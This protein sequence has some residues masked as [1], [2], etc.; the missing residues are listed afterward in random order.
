MTIPNSVVR[1][2]AQV[3][4]Q[5][6]IAGRYAI[7][8]EIGR[9]GMATVYQARDLKL[10]RSVAIKVLN[11]ELS[12]HPTLRLRFIHEARVVAQL[13]HPNIVR[14]FAVE[15]H[16]DLAF[17]I[18]E[19]VDGGTVKEAVRLEGPLSPYKAAGILRDVAW[20]LAY[21]HDH[22]I[23]HRDVKPDNILLDRST[24]RA[25][26]GDFG[27]ALV[28]QRHEL[29]AEGM[30]L[31]TADYVSPEQAAGR[32]IDA[33]SD[34]YSL[35]AA[36]FFMLTGRPPFVASDDAKILMMH[37]SERAP[38]V[39]SFRPDLPE[40]LTR[41]VNSCLQKQPGARYPHSRTIA[42]ELGE[43]LAGRHVVEPEIRSL[44][45]MTSHTASR[46]V[47][48][49]PLS[50][51]VVY[52]LE[53]LSTFGV[54]DVFLLI[55]IGW[56]LSVE[57]LVRPMALFSTVRRILKDGITYKEFRERV[58]AD[59]I[60]DI[61]DPVGPS[62]PR[63]MLRFGVGLLAISAAA[64]SLILATTE[65]VA[66]H[67]EVGLRS[68]GVALFM[69]TVG[70]VGTL[71]IS[72][73]GGPKVDHLLRR[74]IWGGSFGRLLF[75]VAGFRLKAAHK[76]GAVKRQPLEQLMA[77]QCNSIIDQLSSR[78]RRGLRQVRKALA[79]LEHE[80]AEA[81]QRTRVLN[82][83]LRKVRDIAEE[84]D[85]E[86]E[87]EPVGDTG[88]V[89]D[90]RAATEQELLGAL[91][92]AS[93]RLTAIRREMERMRLGLIEVQAGSITVRELRARGMAHT[94]G[95][96]QDRVDGNKLDAN[97]ATTESRPA[98]T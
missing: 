8:R 85:A 14:V 80:A 59:R 75:K 30:T 26:I 82:R 83:A 17:F 42:D 29:T 91:R 87:V 3:T 84:P 22:A 23:V 5:E 60:G 43:F 50:G 2:R 37:R 96:K 46:M 55:W 9:G 77:A 73:S 35:G 56:I 49:V 74:S 88:S 41:I 45:S 65:T 69:V 62:V 89:A 6:V 15:E 20:A 44:I 48:L 70:L 12:S 27:I 53:G 57:I 11:M 31:G 71:I 72:V 1:P 58:L 47:I 64:A 86:L 36:A 61:P 18:M 32:D 76:S 25:L 90:L 21:A 33:R 39:A 67:A 97:A 28:D 95:V 52:A 94:V 24:G 63:L 93:Q 79:R 40:P 7:E 68:L 54:A 92:H 38:S 34:I 10:D 51:I 66:E 78:H 13:S 4:L 98:E 19:Y 81:Q 16:G